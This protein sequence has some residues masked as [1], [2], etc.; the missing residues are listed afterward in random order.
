MVIIV[1]DL[2][3]RTEVTS[4]MQL[5][6]ASFQ[7]MT[8]IEERA[9]DKLA[10]AISLAGIEGEKLLS[11]Q[12]IENE[13][14]ME[15]LKPILRSIAGEI[16]EPLDPLQPELGYK[17]TRNDGEKVKIHRSE[18]WRAMNQALQQTIQGVPQ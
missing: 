18:F 12:S 4:K 7:D 5:K 10:D 16:V 2:F 9:K 8:E 1:T 15:K 17:F 14:L 13:A 11:L 3:G 6:V